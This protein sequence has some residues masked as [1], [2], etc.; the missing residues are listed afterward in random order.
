MEFGEA[1]GKK[2][3]VPRAENSEGTALYEK[4]AR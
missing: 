2:I 1:G 4:D 3:G